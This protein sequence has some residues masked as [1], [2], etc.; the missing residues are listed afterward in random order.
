L[1]KL[2]S[3]YNPVLER[4]RFVV[5]TTKPDPVTMPT[6]WFLAFL[7]VMLLAAISIS[8]LHSERLGLGIMLITAGGSLIFGAFYALRQKKNYSLTKR[9]VGLFLFLGVGQM[10]IEGGV[11]IIWNQWY[12]QHLELF[13]KGF[14]VGVI[15][16]ALTLTAPAISALSRWVRRPTS[17]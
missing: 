4:R 3:V 13:T 5:T 9:I 8:F 10:F 16:L 14:L 17:C 12:N 11:G 15:T 2:I 7:S 6:R 1:N